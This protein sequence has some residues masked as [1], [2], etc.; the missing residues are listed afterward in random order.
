M[1]KTEVRVKNL[2]R[3]AKDGV[4]VNLRVSPGAKITEIKG[5][6]GEDAIKVSVAAPPVEGKANVEIERYLARLF[7]VPRSGVAVVRGGSS[8]DKVILVGGVD[9]GAARESLVGL[10][11]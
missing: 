10:V 6:Y 9:A 2:L 4:Y 11:G 8:R 5:L 3:P 1:A 7:G